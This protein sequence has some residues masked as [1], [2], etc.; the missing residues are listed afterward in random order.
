MRIIA[1][2]VLYK[3]NEMLKCVC[4]NKNMNSVYTYYI[5]DS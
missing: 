3:I 2:G 1:R 4:I 5:S